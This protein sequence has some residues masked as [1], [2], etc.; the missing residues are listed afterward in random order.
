MH[1]PA[2]EGDVFLRVVAGGGASGKALR[3]RLLHVWRVVLRQRALF[4]DA[5]AAWNAHSDQSITFTRIELLR[6]KS[7]IERI[8]PSFQTGFEI[9]NRIEYSEERVLI[10]A[11]L[12]KTG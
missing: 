7:E 4:P 9:L 12:I 3:A 1:F 5:G 11:E 8:A 10:V 2:V 6:T